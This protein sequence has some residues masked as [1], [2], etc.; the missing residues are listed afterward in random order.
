[1]L[2]AAA[3]YVPEEALERKWR[4]LSCAACRRLWHLLVDERSRRAVEGSEKFADGL[5]SERVLETLMTAAAEAQQPDDG[6]PRYWAAATARWVAKSYSL[7]RYTQVPFLAACVAG[8]VTNHMDDEARHRATAPELAAHCDIFRCI[9]GN[10]FRP[11]A[12]NAAWRIGAPIS[13]AEATYDER[14]LPSGHLDLVRLAV[15]ADSLE[16]NGCTDQ[17]IL[18]HLRSPGPHVLGCWPVDLILFRS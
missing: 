3:R 8:S 9:V 4:L 5:L 11:V 15:L 12:P 18:E 13:L 17:A 6:S 7:A 2:A 16:E 10:P 1:M 14:L